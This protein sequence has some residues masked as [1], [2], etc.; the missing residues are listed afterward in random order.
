MAV[1]MADIT[2]L[3]ALTSAG[4]MDCK[5]AL[6]ETDGD[7]EAAV[8]ILRKK[9]Q[10]VAAKREDRQAA[11]G[12]VLSKSTGKFAAIVA[13]NCETDFVA[14]NAGFV[15]LTQKIL[16]AAV[17]AEAKTLDELKALTIDGQTIEALVVEESGKTGEK[18]EI[19]SYEVVAAPSTA[20]YNHFNKKLAAVVGFNLEGVDEK[21]GR[22]VAMQVASMNP[23]AVD[24]DSVPQSVKDTEYNVA[25]EKTKEE[26][27]KKAVEAALKKAGINP[28]LVDSEAHIESNI[29]KGWLTEEEAE[30]A[31]VIAKETAEAKA[32]NLPEQMIK[33][34]AQGRLNKFFKDSCLM[35]QAFV[36]DGELTVGQYLEKVQKGL[37]AV[38]F[39]RVNLNQD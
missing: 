7:I 31:R 34:I 38:E 5:K 32:A 6:A 8:E 30:K 18:T 4:L 39:K 20:A 1:T 16:D 33:N 13:L 23:V 24:A 2:K 3:R 9:G 27:V 10:A 36:Q 29:A 15:A 22:E 12:C 11:E 35:E 21:V 25:V 14:Q 28:N 37:V 17:A 26:Q 19:S